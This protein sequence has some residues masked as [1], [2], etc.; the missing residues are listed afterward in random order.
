MATKAERFKASTE[1]SASVEHQ[2][3]SAKKGAKS[4]GGGEKETEGSIAQKTKGA[5]APARKRPQD[6]N[7]GT[8]RPGVGAD[9][10]K[11]GGDSTADRN[12]SVRAEKKASY[13]LE[14]SATDRPSRKST[15]R[16][17][18]LSFSL[19]R[20]PHRS[21]DRAISELGAGRVAHSTRARQWSE[22]LASLLDSL[23]GVVSRCIWY[24]MRS[25][26]AGDRLG[27]GRPNRR[28]KR[29]EEPVSAG[30]LCPLSGG[31]NGDEG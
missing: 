27:S 7:P 6:K 9:A 24:L 4:I 14:D 5:K 30:A 28:C 13:E 12:R 29:E 18:S 1:F 26:R 20:R 3:T 10:R 8:D 19:R 22:T 23:G 15:R 2:K 11:S 17:W 21:W 16:A 25:S 31:L